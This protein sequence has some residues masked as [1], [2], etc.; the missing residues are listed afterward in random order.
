MMSSWLHV[1]IN[2]LHSHVHARIH[3]QPHICTQPLAP[4]AA[5]AFKRVVPAVIDMPNRFRLYLQ[6]LI[7][8]NLVGGSS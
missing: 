1:F 2:P 7:A 3:N 5:D 8:F 6:V 4:F